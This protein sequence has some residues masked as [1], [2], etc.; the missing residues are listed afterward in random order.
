MSKSK[1]KNSLLFLTT[2]SV[3]LGLVLV[4]A[5]PSVLAQQAAL[6][7]KFEIQLEIEKEDDLD[8]DPDAELNRLTRSIEEYFDE[9]ESF[10]DD[11]RK[12]NG[13]DKFDLDSD[14]FSISETGFVPC[15]VDG[16]PIRHSERNQKISDHWLEPAIT[17]ARYTFENWTS[18]SDCIPTDKFSTGSATKS[19]FSLSFDGSQLRVELSGFRTSTQSAASLAEKFNLASRRFDIDQD[20]SVA[21]K[22]LFQNTIFKAENDQVMI[23]TTLPR[24]SLDSLVKSEKRAN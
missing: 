19:F 13:I 9:L 15:N 23:V 3:Y 18:L 20:T 22:S 6:S 10:I 1:A 4:G 11:L 16:D 12:L 5:S 14:R 17:D 24:G 21:V 7:Q 2:L 8:K